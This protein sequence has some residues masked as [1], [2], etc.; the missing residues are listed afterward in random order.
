MDRHTAVVTAV[1]ISGALVFGL[2]LA[3]LGTIKLNLARRLVLGERQIAGL[4]S[5][6]NLALIPMVLLGGVLTDLI[7]PTWVLLGG[8]LF[9]TLGLY[10]MSQTPTYNRALLAVL[11]IGFGAAAIN[12]ATVVLMPFACFPQ[13]W[14][15]AIITG[16]VFIS[17]GALVTPALTD[18]LFRTIEYRRTVA[19]LGLICLAPAVLC[20]LD[21]LKVPPFDGDV[22]KDTPAEGLPDLTHINIWLA[23]LVFF[24]YAP[25]EGALSVWSTTYLRDLG[26]EEERKEGPGWESWALTSFWGCFLASRLIVAWFS[27]HNWHVD[28][29]RV[30]I[31]CGALITVAAVMSAI[32]LGNMAGAASRRTGRRGLLL[33]GLLLGPVFPT[34]LTMV[35]TEHRDH[36][37]TVYG[38]LFALGS[39]GSLM[40][41]PLFGARANRLRNRDESMQSA[42]RLPMYLALLL[43]LVALA[44]S[45]RAG[46]S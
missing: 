44:Y 13:R 30:L 33:V 2:V 39:V 36:R 6:L 14:E 5:S 18:V 24:F 35:F 46:L 4:L 3:L 7:G 41:A 11:L 15:A 29:E 21:L 16:H 40:I 1:T 22:G 34:L 37:G 20:G 8:S 38:M 12:V 45:L 23:A 26:T 27:S 10:L 42:F 31:T 9:T 28:P 17:L 32:V 25:L 43:A 19:F